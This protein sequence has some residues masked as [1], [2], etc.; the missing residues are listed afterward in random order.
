MDLD[1]LLHHYFNA[2]DPDAIDPVQLAAGQEK[3]RV[4]FSIE[5]DP[6][7]RFALWTF[8]EAF[9][10]A[11]LPADAFKDPALKR[12]ADDYLSAAWRFERD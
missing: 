7:R 9:G 1:A 4:D 2:T 8:M 6:A 3:L 10:I 5:R 11:P 12:A